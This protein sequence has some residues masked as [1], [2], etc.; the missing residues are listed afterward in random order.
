[1]GLIV[2]ILLHYV[3]DFAFQTN[4][5]EKYK[6]KLRYMFLHIFIVFFIF[7][8][9]MCLLGDI[10]DFY[11]NIKFS[12]INALLHGLVDYLMWKLYVLSIKKRKKRIKRSR[13]KNKYWYDH[14]FYV[15]IGLD[16]Y[17]HILVLYLL[18]K[19]L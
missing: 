2:L 9:G 17:I 18:I 8:T 16:Q 5:I 15:I 11:Y 6:N 13:I 14:V 12:L 1:M 19:Y 4:G 3:A 7:F 10:Q